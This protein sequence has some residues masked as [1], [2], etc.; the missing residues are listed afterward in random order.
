[1]NATADVAL[2][3]TP[4]LFAESL[5]LA[6]SCHGFSTAVVPAA[7]PTS[8]LVARILTR[9][10]RIVVIGP[11]L[12]SAYQWLDLVPALHRSHRVVVVLMPAYEPVRWGEALDLGATSVLSVATGLATMVQAL[13]E[14][15]AG[16]TDMPAMRRL[17]LVHQW[18]RARARDEEHH[19]RLSLLSRRERQVLAELAEGKRVGDIARSFHVSEETVRTQVK[20]VLAKLNVNSQIAAVAV[21]REVGLR[22]LG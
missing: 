20:S 19:V 7:D 16:R 4:R 21:V 9:D 12:G 22:H 10:P 1:M 18:R 6:L 13:S 2:V 11:D 3:E 14:A 17:E 8:A 5:A 15:M